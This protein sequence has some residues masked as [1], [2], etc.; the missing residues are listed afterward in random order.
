MCLFI[1]YQ[2]VLS[3]FGVAEYIINAERTNFFNQNREGI[4]SLIG[5]IALFLIGTQI[6]TFSTQETFQ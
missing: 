6:G 1:V 5:Y 4:L 3:H 2:V